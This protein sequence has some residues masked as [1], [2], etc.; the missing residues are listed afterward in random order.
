MLL[1]GSYS[2]MYKHNIIIL[3]PHSAIYVPGFQ[4]VCVCMWKTIYISITNPSNIIVD[5]PQPPSE[6]QFMYTHRYVMCMCMSIH[7]LMYLPYRKWPQQAALLPHYI[8]SE[9]VRA[10]WQSV[11]MWDTNLAR[12]RCC[13]PF[14][15]PQRQERLSELWLYVCCCAQ[16]CAKGMQW[17]SV[18]THKHFMYVCV[19]VYPRLPD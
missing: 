6:M 5:L 9:Y 8:Y 11:R 10:K 7:V 16:L 3:S 13:A 1:R 14:T 19:H 15:P 4:N 12:C 18:Y 17:L 2:N